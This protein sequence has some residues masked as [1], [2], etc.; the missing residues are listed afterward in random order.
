MKLNCYA[1]FIYFLAIFIN[2]HIKKYKKNNIRHGKKG[3]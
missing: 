3:Q 2:I 1:L